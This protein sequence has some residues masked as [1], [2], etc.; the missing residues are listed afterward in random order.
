IMDFLVL[1]EPTAQSVVALRNS[2][3]AQF[4]L[5]EWKDVFK[6]L[7]DPLRQRQRDALVGY[8][9]TRP[10]TVNGKVFNFFDANDLYAFFLI[11]VEMQADTLI[12]RMVLAH[13]VVQLFVD[14]VFMGLEDPASFP[15]SNVDDAKD[16]WSW[17]S[18]FRVWEANRKVFL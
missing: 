15:N 9:T 6:P 8:L 13:L 7:R 3:R 1:A 4:S 16:V 14:R 2:F 10:I 18:R 17:M 5:Q 11:D 12:S